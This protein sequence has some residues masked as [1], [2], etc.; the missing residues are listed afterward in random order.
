MQ[1]LSRSQ[2]K[3]KKKLIILYVSIVFAFLNKFKVNIKVEQILV[4]CHIL[5]RKSFQDKKCGN[6]F[7][8]Y[9]F[10]YK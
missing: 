2:I 10:L 7:K 9:T 6:S 5:K 8:I 3:W 4:S 1:K